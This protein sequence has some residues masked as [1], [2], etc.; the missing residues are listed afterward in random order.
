MNRTQPKMIGRR[1]AFVWRPG[2]RAPSRLL[3]L[4]LVLL[5]A[6]AAEAQQAFDIDA[7][8]FRSARGESRLDV[9]VHV[10]YQN[11][12]F[13]RRGDGFASNYTVTASVHR[14][15]RNDRPAG[16]VLRRSWDRTV[17]AG[18]YNI[19]QSDTLAEQSSHSIELPEGR[20]VLQ[21]RVE[22]RATARGA[23]I[24]RVVDVL[25]M[26]G[27]LAVS[28]IVVADRY[29][30]RTRTATPNVSA[31][32]PSDRSSFALFF[33]IYAGQ[34]ERLRVRYDI[35]QLGPERRAGG[36][37]GLF[38]RR[39]REMTTVFEVADWVT[40]AALTP[41]GRQFDTRRLDVGEYEAVVRLERA[42]GSLV[43]ERTRAFAVRWMGLFEQLQDLDVAI[44]QLRYIAKDREIQA[45]R[46]ARSFQERFRLFQEFWDK[47]D[48]SPGS[49]RNERMEEYYYRVAYAARHYG[50][51]EGTGW[52]TDRGEVYIRFGEPDRVENRNAS[53]SARPSQIWYYSGIGRRFIFVDESGSGDFRLLVP[54]WDERTR[55]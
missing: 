3:L 51:L 42:D 13:V 28:D 44:A 40:A 22:D 39:E 31:S 45:M 37:F 50:R 2:G 12:R 48:P 38:G 21:M 34:P 54:I 25:P 23:T 30:S 33:E 36:L 15:G 8:T 6:S 10:P 26:S 24:E 49:G 11:L 7:V 41:V 4:A 5:V 52:E 18:N 27:D 55:M 19:T 53:G 20:Y 32:I 29:D 16:L 43:A 46:E 9:H 35:Q 1:G 14:A 47:R 17:E